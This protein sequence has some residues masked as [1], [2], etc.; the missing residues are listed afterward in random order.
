MMLV[1]IRP[2]VNLIDLNKSGVL[3]LNISFFTIW[4]GSARSKSSKRTIKL[5]SPC[6]IE[7]AEKYRPESVTPDHQVEL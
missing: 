5:A 7:H 1:L 3:G 4:T 2:A 6:P